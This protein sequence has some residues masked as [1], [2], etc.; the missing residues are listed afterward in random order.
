MFRYINDENERNEFTFN[1]IKKCFEFHYNNCIQYKVFCDINEIEP[2]DINEFDDLYKIPQIP[3]AVFKSL[4]VHSV[5]KRACK[6]CTSSGTK[7]A[8]SRIYRDEATIRSFVE[9]IRMDAGLLYGLTIDNCVVYNLGPSAAEAGDIWIAYVTG[10]LRNI[11]E[12]HN[13]MHSGVLETDA[14]VEKLR[15]ADGTKRIVLLG[16]PALFMKVF[17][18]MERN[19][20]HLELPAD[21]IV[22]TAGG[23]KV[24][25]DISLGRDAI[26]SMFKMYFGI[27]E[28]QYFDVYNQV[29][30]N[31]PFFEC[32]YHKK[33]IPAGFL[34]IIRDPVTLEKLDDG[35]EGIMTFIDS[36]SKSYPAFVMTDDIASVSEGCECGIG[37]QV[38]NYVRRV[39]AVE[40]KGCA[41]KLD[42]KMA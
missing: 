17:A 21:A 34:A 2:S 19:N 29:E 6:C 8:V 30:S 28:S 38:F 31:T 15:N 14:L 41:L 12:T 10:F 26:C 5:D 7:G 40:T 1:E 24:K 27:D 42:Q 35:E 33:H 3:T 39:T 9:T 11:L 32:K 4:D 18:D 36:S 22:F 23:W 13:F 16:A 37:G 20:I 25:S